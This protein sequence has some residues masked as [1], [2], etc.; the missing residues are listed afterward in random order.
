MTFS[1]S[2]CFALLCLSLIFNLFGFASIRLG[3]RGNLMVPCIVG[4][5]IVGT[6]RQLGSKVTKYKVGQ[7]VGVGAMVKAC[8]DKKSCEPCSLD[9]DNYCPKSVFTYNAKFE[10]GQQAQG[11]YADGIRTDENY[12]FAISD[13]ITSAEAAPLMC[14]GTTVFTPLHRAKVGK[15]SKVGI[16]GVGG[17]GHLA[18]QFAAKMGAHVVSISTSSK[19]KEDALKLGAKEHLDISDKEAV[20][21]HAGSLTHI[22]VS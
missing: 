13:K 3:C 7:R 1:D 4:H 18:I 8:L 10:D 11:G 6:V 21:K 12:V 5:E 15:D 2:I 14:A 9:K 19:K 22:L 20:K 17:L 16:I